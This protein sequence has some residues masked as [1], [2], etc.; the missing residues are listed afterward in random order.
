MA[1]IIHHLRH[2]PL[3]RPAHY[4]GNPW[5][6]SQ[7]GIYGVCGTLADHP[8]PVQRLDVHPVWSADWVGILECAPPR[9]CLPYRSR[10]RCRLCHRRPL[11][12]TFSMVVCW[13][14]VCWFYRRLC[15]ATF[16]VKGWHKS[17][18]GNISCGKVS[19]KGVELSAH[20]RSMTNS[21]RLI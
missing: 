3:L 6:G 12:S 20:K 5:A 17:L 7:R 19:S 2:P 15:A 9:P 4:L 14:V 11:E 10:T 18:L 13:Y 16:A 1:T 21:L 8:Q